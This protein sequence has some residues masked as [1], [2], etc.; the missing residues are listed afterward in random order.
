MESTMR[1]TNAFVVT[2]SFA[3]FIHEMWNIFFTGAI[4]A[5]AILCW[6]KCVQII[7][8]HENFL[9]LRWE[10]NLQILR[11]KLHNGENWLI[12]LMRFVQVYRSQP[13]PCLE[14]IANFTLQVDAWRKVWVMSPTVIMAFPSHSATHTSSTLIRFSLRTLPE[15]H[16]TARNMRVSSF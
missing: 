2:V 3:V 7:L 10:I 16:R 9:L 5:S 13:W 4:L 11:N 14:F 1:R 15:A 8:P 6:L 12:K